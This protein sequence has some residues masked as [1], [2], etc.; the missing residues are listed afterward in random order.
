MSALPHGPTCLSVAGAGCFSP[1]W[2][3]RA[4]QGRRP[5][6]RH[7]SSLHVG[8]PPP[9]EGFALP[10]PRCRGP[11][12]DQPLSAVVR[13]RK[14]PWTCGRALH[15]RSGATLRA[16]PAKRLWDW[17]AARILYVPLP[18]VLGSA[19]GRRPVK[20][21]LNGTRPTRVVSTHHRCRRCLTA[22]PV[23]AVWHL[24]WGAGAPQRHEHPPT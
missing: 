3:S 24:G 4:A 23:R 18:T 8:R 9:E 7:C 11:F 12:V 5:P 14:R 10:A 17:F 22:T 21:R 13:C 19:C 16:T 20:R 2:T 15:K 6:P 1:R